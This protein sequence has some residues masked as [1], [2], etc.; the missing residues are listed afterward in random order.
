LKKKEADKKEIDE[1]DVDEKDIDEKDKKSL[2]RVD[3]VFDYGLPAIKC[4]PR[5]LAYSI[6]VEGSD[7]TIKPL[8]NP[9]IRHFVNLTVDAYNEINLENTRCF[10]IRPDTREETRRRRRGLI[11]VI[12][13]PF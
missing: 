6:T 12:R 7:L 5:V 8:L 10:P 1:K 2:D 13:L 9:N 3:I 11:S 4:Q